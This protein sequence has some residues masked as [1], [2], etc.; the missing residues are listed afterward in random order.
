MSPSL[1]IT[2]SHGRDH[3]YRL[4]SFFSPQ[5]KTLAS[6]LIHGICLIQSLGINNRE[7]VAYEEKENVDT[8]IF[9]G[10]GKSCRCYLREQFS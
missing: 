9:L 8:N 7:D 2:N 5:K 10:A 6:F 3:Q 1:L 4:A